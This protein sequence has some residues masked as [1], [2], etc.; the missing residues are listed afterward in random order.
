MVTVYETQ[1]SRAQLDARLAQQ[2]GKRKRHGTY[3]P[4]DGRNLHTREG[5]ERLYPAIGYA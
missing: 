4:R 1:R 3:P 5:I 2:M